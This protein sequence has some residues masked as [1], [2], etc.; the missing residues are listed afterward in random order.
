LCTV[1]LYSWN[2]LSVSLH[3]LHHLSAF[4]T[5]YQ[6]MLLLLG[7]EIIDHISYNPSFLS[8]S[9][10]GISSNTDAKQLS[11]NAFCKWKSI[12]NF[13]L[14]LSMYLIT[15][16]EN[17][18]ITHVVSS[19]SHLHNPMLFF[20]SYLSLTDI[21]LNTSIVLKM[22]ID[23]TE[24]SQCMF[25]KDNIV[26]LCYVMFPWN[27]MF[28]HQ[29]P[30]TTMLPLATIWVTQSILTGDPTFCCFWSICSLTLWL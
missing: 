27:A 7:P 25:T 4:L 18:L 24:Q 5:R 13:C 20:L 1:D 6:I 2:I 17:L 28:S 3:V 8:N 16:L 21:C 23:I 10:V 19:Y 15:I 22:L 12:Q 29:W 14:F 11:K 30:K 9:S 26:T